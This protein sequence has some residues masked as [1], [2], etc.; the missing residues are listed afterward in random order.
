MPISALA[1]DVNMSEAPDPLEASSRYRT[2]SHDIRSGFR[3]NLRFY[4]RWTRRTVMIVHNIHCF[5]CVVSDGGTWSHCVRH[6]AMIT[7][8]VL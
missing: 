8:T 3:A 2:L 1:T 7:Y 5:G 4:L 6:K